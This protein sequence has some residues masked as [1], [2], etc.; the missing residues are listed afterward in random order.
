[1]LGITA[2]IV[3]TALGRENRNSPFSLPA[4]DLHGP[5]LLQILVHVEDL[6]EQMRLMAPAL[7]Q[8]LVLCTLE[9]VHQDGPVLGMRALVDDHPRSLAR[10]QATDIR[11]T[12][13][14]R[15]QQLVPQSSLGVS[16]SKSEREKGG[17]PHLLRNDDIQVMFRLIDVGAHGHNARDA[18]R[19]R[20]ARSRAGRVHDAVLGAAQ[21]VGA[22]AEAV[23]HAAA[24]DAGAVGVGVDVDFDGRVHADDAEA[25]D[26]LGRVGDLLRAQEELGVVVLPLRQRKG[27]G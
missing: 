3:A 25:A 11:Q 13:R 26:D 9:V 10:A 2:R 17:P 22:A 1:M 27:A 20:L 18:V 6:E 14:A 8:A 4:R 15:C 12:L 7:A 5:I 24:H 23:E 19:I 21:E 16:E